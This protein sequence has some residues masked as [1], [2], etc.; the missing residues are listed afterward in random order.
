V[1]IA[2]LKKSRGGAD[3]LDARHP[4]TVVGVV[5]LGSERLQAEAR[6]AETQRDDV[7]IRDERVGHI[8]ERT[9]GPE[10]AVPTS[11]VGLAST[12][13]R[14]VC[15]NGPLSA[16]CQAPLGATWAL[17]VSAQSRTSPGSSL[18]DERSASVTTLVQLSISSASLLAMITIAPARA[19]SIR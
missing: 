5:V 15:R 3:V 2:R 4:G 10:E 9:C 1:A 11:D 12:P 17:Q 14:S 19:A 6:T 18:S 13:H 8:I 16:R 7:L